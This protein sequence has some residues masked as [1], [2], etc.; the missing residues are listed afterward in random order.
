MILVDTN[1]ILSLLSPDEKERRKVLA[2]WG[3]IR[4]ETIY[5]TLPVISEVTNFLPLK[6]QLSAFM[7][8]VERMGFQFFPSEDLVEWRDVLT[9]MIRYAEHE[10]DFTDAYLVVLSAANKKFKVWTRDSEFTLIWRR[11][12]G[13]AVPMAVKR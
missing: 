9:W 7:E 11:P 6:H 4:K 1:I 2:Q 8:L 5:I 13:A 10:P 12:D 3:S